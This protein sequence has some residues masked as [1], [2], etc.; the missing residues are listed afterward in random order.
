MYANGQHI[1]VLKHLFMSHVDVESSLMWLS[2]STT[3][4]RHFTTILTTTTSD[5]ESPKSDLS[6][7]DI[8]V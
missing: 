1:N 7:V 4:P 8:I 3:Q 6:R 5:G 2:A